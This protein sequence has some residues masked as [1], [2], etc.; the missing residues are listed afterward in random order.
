MQ[1]A[2]LIT[3]LTYLTLFFAAGQIAARAA[4]RGIWLFGAAQGRA[5]W[6]AIGFR[7]AFLL[8]A[9][10]VSIGIYNHPHLPITAAGLIGLALCNIGAMLAFAAQLSMGASWRVGVQA[11]SV[12]PLVSGG[13]YRYSRNPT[14]IGQGFLLVG[15]AAVSLGALTIAAVILFALSARAQVADEEFALADQ[16]GADYLAFKSRVPRW[17]GRTR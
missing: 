16:H 1:I 5:R 12:G 7:A 2:A 13:L 14:F 8:A 6:A 3:L 11:G 17:I 10:S 4:G 15:V 9:I